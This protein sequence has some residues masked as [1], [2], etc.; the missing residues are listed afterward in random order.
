MVG[1]RICMSKDRDLRNM[2]FFMLFLAVH[3]APTW[4]MDKKYSKHLI[5]YF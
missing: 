3:F 1:L 2:L 4:W 5:F